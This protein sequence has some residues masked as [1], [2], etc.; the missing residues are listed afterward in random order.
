MAFFPEVLASSFERVVANTE[1]D[2]LFSNSNAFRLR[3][4]CG[5]I[6]DDPESMGADDNLPEP[7]T[8]GRGTQP[9]LW[10]WLGGEGRTERRK[11]TKNGKDWNEQ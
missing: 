4:R 3:R 8:T 9:G 10:I 2:F 7:L 11:R 5:D 6:A 1:Q